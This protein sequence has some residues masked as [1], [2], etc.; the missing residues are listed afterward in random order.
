MNRHVLF[1][2]ALSVL[3]PTGTARPTEPLKHLHVLMVL[4]TRDEDLKDTLVHDKN[5]LHKLLRTGIPQDRYTV[6]FFEGN[7]ATPAR[8]L[9]Y[10]KEL[11][12]TVKP[13]EG[14]LFYVSCHGGTWKED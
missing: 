1:L 7:D 10:Y 11:K 12:K 6:T 14:I 2:A 9:E 8:I 3:A 5:N 4:D 13:D